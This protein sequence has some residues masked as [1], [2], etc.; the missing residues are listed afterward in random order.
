L[1]LFTISTTEIYQLK[2]NHIYSSLQLRVAFNCHTV[3]TSIFGLFLDMHSHFS[4]TVIFS[5][6]VS[7]INSLTIK[8]QSSKSKQKTLTAS[9]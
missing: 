4:N 3:L 9:T 5:S 1:T 2:S 7:T 6:L 8:S